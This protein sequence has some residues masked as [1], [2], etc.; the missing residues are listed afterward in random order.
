[1]TKKQ[2]FSFC[3]RLEQIRGRIKEFSNGQKYLESADLTQ[4]SNME[5]TLKFRRNTLGE[6]RWSVHSMVR[7]HYYIS[8]VEELLKEAAA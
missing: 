3:Y 8:K 4:L 2:Y 5:T 6:L 7:P 1:M